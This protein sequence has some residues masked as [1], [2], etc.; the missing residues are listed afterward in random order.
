MGQKQEL[1]G[2][3]IGTGFPFKTPQHFDAYL[4]M[5]KSISNYATDLRRAGSAALDLAYVAAGRLD[6]YWEIG[7]QPW[8]MAAGLLL[9]QEAGGYVG[10]LQGGASHFKSGN[11]VAGNQKVYS[12][13]VREIR[14]HVT[15]ALAR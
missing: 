7:L 5:F 12:G 15:P 3:L 2:A 4:A 9:I 13:L 10:D 1:E 6:G 8:D 11:V 14:P